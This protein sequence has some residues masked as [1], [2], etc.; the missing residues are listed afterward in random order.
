MQIPRERVARL[1]TFR[2]DEEETV[3][4][5]RHTASRKKNYFPHPHLKA[6]GEN[7][8]SAISHLHKPL[9]KAT[10]HW[11]LSSDLWDHWYDT[12]SRAV[13]SRMSRWQALLLPKN[14]SLFPTSLPPS[15]PSSDL[16]KGRHD[17]CITDVGIILG[18]GRTCARVWPLSDECWLS[19]AEHKEDVEQN[20][21]C[22]GFQ[23]IILRARICA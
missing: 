16:H 7:C 1:P 17:H 21:F 14:G 10:V 9:E 4:W 12:C 22:S 5:G 13:D 23:R 20:L 18:T 8:V 6:Y 11:G 3:K 15:L 19:L 2:R